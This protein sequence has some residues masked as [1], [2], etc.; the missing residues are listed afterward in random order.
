MGGWKA[1]GSRVKDT[2]YEEQQTI[3]IFKFQAINFKIF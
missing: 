1:G 2:Y 3:I